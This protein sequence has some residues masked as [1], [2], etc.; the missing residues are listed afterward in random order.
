MNEE[1]D[2]GKIRSTALFHYVDPHA[3]SGLKN[4]IPTSKLKRIIRGN[5]V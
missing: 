4:M 2:M 3:A 5:Y 1:C